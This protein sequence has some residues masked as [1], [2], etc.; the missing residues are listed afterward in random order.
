[1]KKGRITDKTF[2]VNAGLLFGSRKKFLKGNTFSM[3][4]INIDDDD[5]DDDDDDNDDE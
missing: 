5:D 2:S 4:N 1:M 3:K